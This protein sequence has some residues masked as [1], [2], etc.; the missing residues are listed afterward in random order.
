[1][2]VRVPGRR[3]RRSRSRSERRRDKRERGDRAERDKE[4]DR[5][6]DR[7]RPRRDRDRK[8]TKVKP[9]DIKVKE[10]PNDGETHM[11]TTYIPSKLYFLTVR[12]KKNTVNLNS[13]DKG[14]FFNF[15]ILLMLYIQCTKCCHFVCN[16]RTNNL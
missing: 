12:K 14:Y 6:R 15:I 11:S 13:A 3:R 16:L 5:D 10:E 9:E 7:K 8:E 4:R 1:M 2:G